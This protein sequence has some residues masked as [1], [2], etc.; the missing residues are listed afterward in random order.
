MRLISLLSAALWVDFV[1]MVIT[2][3]LPGQHLSFLPPTGALKLWYDKFGVAA[4]AADVFSLML[5]VLLAMF[6]FPTAYG[7]QLVL[8]A[9]LVQLLHD[10]LFYVIVILGLPQGQNSMIDVFKTYANEGRW[11]ILLADALMVS[12]VVLIAEMSDIFFTYRA[13]AFQA[14]LGMYSLIYI[15]YTK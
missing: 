12:S 10:I 4:V 6:L 2:K 8:A 3:I 11:T 9:V 1:V 13:I 15:T 14:I 7:F 5:G